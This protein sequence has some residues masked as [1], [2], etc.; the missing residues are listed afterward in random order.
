MAMAWRA[1][2]TKLDTFFARTGMLGTRRLIGGKVGEALDRNPVTGWFN[3]GKYYYNII[4]FNI[5]SLLF[6]YFE[7]Q[8][9]YR[10]A[11]NYY[12]RKYYEVLNSYIDSINYSA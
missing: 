11:V 3:N 12:P 8:E 1:F 10:F 4:L 6:I 7:P 5:I 9:N 2:E